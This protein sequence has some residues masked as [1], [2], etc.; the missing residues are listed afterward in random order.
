LWSSLP[1]PMRSSDMESFTPLSVVGAL[2]NKKIRFMRHSKF[3]RGYGKRLNATYTDAAS[4][5]ATVFIDLGYEEPA[6]DAQYV[7]HS[8]R[9]SRKPYSESGFPLGGS[10]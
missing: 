5:C 2:L 1:W 4:G 7:V 6:P 10:P 3:S 8:N 9:G